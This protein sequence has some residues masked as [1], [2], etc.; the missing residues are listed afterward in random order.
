[1]VRTTNISSI[2]SLISDILRGMLKMKKEPIRILQCVSN[3]DRAGIETMLMNF[4][5]NMD[6]E[7]IQFDFLVNKSKPGDYDEEIISLGGKIYR[8]P[9]LSPFKFLEYQ[10]YME[11]LFNEHPEYKVIHCQNEAMGYYALKAAKDNN[12]PVRI[13]HSHNT[14]TRIDYKYPIK[15]FCKSQLK[16]VANYFV[17]CS[18][19]AGE[20]LFNEEVKIINNAINSEKFLYNPNIRNEVRKKYNLRNKFV[21]GH[22]GRFEA[23]KNHSYLIDIFYEIYQ[24]DNEAV[25]L[26][27]G[28]GSLEEKVKQK[29]SKLNISNNV[30]FTGNI[31]NVNEMYQAM[32]VFV[33]P[34]FHEGLPV[35][36]IE[37][38]AAGL[39]CILSDTITNEVKITNNI[40]FMSLRDSAYNW[41]KKVLYYKN[42]DRKNEYENIVKFGYDIKE[43]TKVLSEF[44]LRLY[45]GD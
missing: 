12:I 14:I 20:Y 37:A 42:Y 22:V 16:K 24:L 39:P 7:Q 38:Q 11:N 8:T 41:A 44:Y 40:H 10:K 15:I 43:A 36:G 30:I 5:R 23:Q 34:S 31:P 21:V 28:N 29:I 1:M 35:V 17:A 18:K 3:M 9:G 2:E 32:D 33:L 4:Y 25:L 6:R 45:R 26:L 13:S 27:I 19:L